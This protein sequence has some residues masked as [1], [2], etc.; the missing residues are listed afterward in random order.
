[1]ASRSRRRC[2]AAFG[3]VDFA[4][5]LAATT[6]ADN[7]GPAPAVIHLNAGVSITLTGVNK[8]QLQSDDFLI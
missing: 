2:S 7:A 3:F 4:A 5:V 8:D 6:D 1:L